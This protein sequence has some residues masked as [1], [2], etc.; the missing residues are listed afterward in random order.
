MVIWVNIAQFAVFVKHKV[1]VNLQS[2]DG[3]WWA[4][5]TNQDQWIEADLGVDHRIESVVTQGAVD[6]DTGNQY[7]VTS[8]YVSYMSDG[9]SAWVDVPTL[10][11]AN[12]DATTLVTNELPPVVV[13]RR[14]RI[15]PWTWND[16]RIML[17]W[18]LNGRIGRLFALRD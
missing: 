1:S 2:G 17:R 3:A 8:Y 12:S 6:A 4:S 15:R 13:A 10:F 16:D 7:Y 14:F 5:E 18:E 11:T 9:A